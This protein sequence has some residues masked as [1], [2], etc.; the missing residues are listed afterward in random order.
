MFEKICKDVQLCIVHC[1]CGRKR[2]RSAK[3]VV[4]PARR[5]WNRAVKLVSI[6][7]RL[8]NVHIVQMCMPAFCS[9]CWVYMLILSAF[10]RCYNAETPGRS[11]TWIRSLLSELY[12]TGLTRWCFF[13]LPILDF[14]LDVLCFVDEMNQIASVI[15]LKFKNV[16]YSAITSTWE[17]DECQVVLFCI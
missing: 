12:D 8:S 16:R 4:T 10:D 13:L 1:A 5:R 11:F 15:L 7:S 14:E 3:M 6:F 9:I 17:V 2:R